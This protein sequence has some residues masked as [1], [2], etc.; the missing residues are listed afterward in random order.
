MMRSHSKAKRKIGEAHVLNLLRQTAGV[1]GKAAKGNK[2]A[3]IFVAVRQAHAN[4]VG[5]GQ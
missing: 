5:M 1:K 3:S 4:G 2:N